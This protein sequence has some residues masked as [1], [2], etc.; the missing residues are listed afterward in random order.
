MVL[1]RNKEGRNNVTSTS[2]SGICY[3]PLYYRYQGASGMDE[4]MSECVSG[5][6]QLKR[7]GLEVFRLSAQGQNPYQKASCRLTLWLINCTLGT[8]KGTG[9]GF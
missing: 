6:P 1:G 2:I 8:W 7:G 9:G 5:V 4:E 3:Q